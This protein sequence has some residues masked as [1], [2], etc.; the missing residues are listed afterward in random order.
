V[1][2]VAMTLE[3]AL[4]RAQMEAIQNNSTV[5]FSLRWGGRAYSIGTKEFKLPNGVL[6]KS[7]TSPTIMFGK[8]GE[9]LGNVFTI[10]GDQNSAIL[11]VEPLF[12]N[13]HVHLVKSTGG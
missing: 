9:S 3:R 1:I 4:R 8:Y 12:G 6:V 13:I 5:I 7:L 2:S 11:E 10:S